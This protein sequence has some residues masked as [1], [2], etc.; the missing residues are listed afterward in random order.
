MVTR[1]IP[2]MSPF[3]N[4]S[5]KSIQR[6]SNNLWARHCKPSSEQVSQHQV[7]W[8]INAHREER[9]QHQQVNWRAQPALLFLAGTE[10]PVDVLHGLGEKVA[11]EQDRPGE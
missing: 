1:C 5:T 2:N 10:N 4:S 6:T 8:K 11:N 9:H 3:R 7:R